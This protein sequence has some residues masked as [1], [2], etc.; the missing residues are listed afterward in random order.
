MP[1]KG[2]YCILTYLLHSP[3]N[4]Q[5]LGFDPKLDNYVA[6]AVGI[7]GG[8][9]ILFFV[10]KILKMALCVEHEVS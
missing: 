1:H 5:A 8:F 6:N 4:P 7:F 2:R 3:V 9:Y 10:E